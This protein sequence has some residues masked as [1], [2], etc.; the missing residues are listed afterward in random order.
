MGEARGAEAVTQPKTRWPWAEANAVATEL[1]RAISPHCH[2]TY[3]AIAGSLRRGKPDVGDIEL[4]LVPIPWGGFDQA[5]QK[6]MDEGELLKRKNVNESY[7]YG[8]LNK[9]MVHQ[10]G[11]WVDIFTATKANWGMRLMVRT[12]DKD[13]NIAVMAKLKQLG[14]KGHAYGGITLNVNDLRH[15][16]IDCPDE[17]IIFQILGIPFVPP[18]KRDGNV[19]YS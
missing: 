19:L 12:G 5:L 7:V 6:M 13:F 3:A 1:L 18:E 9:L 16:D 15:E 14:H 2:A 4:V 11:I 17:E 8:P 10:S